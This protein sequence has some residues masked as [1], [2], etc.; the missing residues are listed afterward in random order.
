MCLNIFFLNVYLIVFFAISLQLSTSLDPGLVDLMNLDTHPM[1]LILLFPVWVIFMNSTWS[2]PLP[3]ISPL[4][5]TTSFSFLGIRD[6]VSQNGN[7]V[8]FLYI[9]Y[10]IFLY[11][12]WFQRI[13]QCSVRKKRAG[14]IA[15]FPAL[16]EVT[17]EEVRFR[18]S[19][20]QLGDINGAAAVSVSPG[21]NSRD[22]LSVHTTGRW[23]LLSAMKKRSVIYEVSKESQIMEENS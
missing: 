13:P 9:C 2:S 23:F 7:I 11:S 20:T 1:W 10:S 21:P 3:I 14:F 19:I 12:L 5:E 18:N 16:D 6:K 22:H 15:V 8:L 17:L 4:W